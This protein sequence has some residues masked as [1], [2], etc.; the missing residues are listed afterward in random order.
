MESND[1]KKDEPKKAPK[2]ADGR[3][4][5]TEDATLTAFGLQDATTA[6]VQ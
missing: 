1:K 2:A 4:L 5:I 6:A 3:V